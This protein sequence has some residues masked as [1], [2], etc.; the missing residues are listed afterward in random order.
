M[1]WYSYIICF[2][3]I[4]LGCFFGVQFYNDVTAMS[5]TNGSINISN[6]FSQ[7]SF[8]YSNNAVVFYPTATEEAY[9]FEIELVK[10]EGFDAER[11]EYELVLNDFKLIDT[12]FKAGAVIS[13]VYMDFYDVEGN[14][15]C[16]GEM[17]IRILFLSGKTQ[18][19]L[20]CPDVESATYFEQ[21]FND[22]G[23]RLAV[24]EILE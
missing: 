24:I 13:D 7:E 10:T 6:Q 1:K 11:K 9:T 5:Y 3:L 12:T 17:S 19:K 4:G 14:E 18:L 23:I 16:N 8:F 20:S 2:I 15:M 22:N 21:Y